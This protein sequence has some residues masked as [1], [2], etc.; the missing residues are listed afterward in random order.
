MPT[1]VKIQYVRAL[2]E[3]LAAHPSLSKAQLADLL[4][5]PTKAGETLEPISADDA[6]RQV[7][8]QEAAQIQ[9]EAVADVPKTAAAQLAA[10]A[11]TDRMDQFDFAAGDGS[12]LTSLVTEGLLATTTRDAILAAATVDVPGPSWA[13][14]LGLGECLPEF[15]WQV[16]EY[17]GMAEA[18]VKEQLA[19]AL[20]ARWCRQYALSSLTVEETMAMPAYAVFRDSIVLPYTEMADPQTAD[21]VTRAV[22]NLIKEVNG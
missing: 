9:A 12:L 13:Q 5:A 4:N 3:Q 20:L 11:W 10:Q 15:L 1:I 6:K 16:D 2:Q 19:A 18:E 8:W 22:W 7:G 17:E 21:E 14:T